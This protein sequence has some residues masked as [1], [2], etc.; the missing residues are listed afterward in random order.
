MEERGKLALLMMEYSNLEA[1]WGTAYHLEFMIA[2]RCEIDLR[3]V[4]ND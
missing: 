3:K 2:M 1:A 4:Q